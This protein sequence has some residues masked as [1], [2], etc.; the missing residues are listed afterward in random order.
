MNGKL[1]FKKFAGNRGSP[2]FAQ[3]YG[4]QAADKTDEF[5]DWA[6]DVGQ[7]IFLSVATV[8]LFWRVTSE[9]QR[10]VR[11]LAGGANHR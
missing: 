11:K 1:F 8:L 7:R 5:R 6:S 10:D 3:G 2:S 4:G 9:S